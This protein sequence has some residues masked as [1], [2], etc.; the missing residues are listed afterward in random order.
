MVLNIINQQYYQD[1]LQ[2]VPSLFL[3]QF[4]MEKS[5]IGYV[6]GTLVN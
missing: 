6:Q 5:E 4:G 2:D 3:G 1:D